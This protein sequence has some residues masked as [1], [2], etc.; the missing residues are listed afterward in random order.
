MWKAEHHCSAL[1]FG[2]AL[3]A[4]D[5]GLLA[6][7]PRLELCEALGAIMELLVLLWS[8]CSCKALANVELLMLL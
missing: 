5:R 7:L 1:D 4:L 3:G 2:G 8:T 6:S